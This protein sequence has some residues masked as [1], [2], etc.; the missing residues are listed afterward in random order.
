HTPS[1]FWE[2][3]SRSISAALIVYLTEVLAGKKSWENNATINNAINVL[4][5][6]VVKEVILRF[7][8][9]EEEYPHLIN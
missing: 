6:V 9:R 2:S 7:Q 3:A 5:G 4:E 1:Y 8:H